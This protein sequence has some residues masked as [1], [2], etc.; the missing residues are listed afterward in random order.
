L[1]P[2]SKPARAGA[3][4]APDPLAGWYFDSNVSA[5]QVGKRARIAARLCGLHY[6]PDVWILDNLREI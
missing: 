4:Q 1:A 2:W 5:D 6:G 3:G